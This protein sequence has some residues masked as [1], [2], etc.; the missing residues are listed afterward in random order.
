[1][2]GSDPDATLHWL[3]RMTE[4]GENPEFIARRIVICAAEDVGLA[5]PMALVVATSALQT[6]HFVGWPEAR[7][8]LAEAAL[9]IACAPKSNA[10]YMAIDAAIADA[11]RI[12]FNEVPIHL[13][14]SHYKGAKKFGHGINYKYPHDFPGH[15]TPQE[16]RPKELAE[17]RYYF[18]SKNGKEQKIG[19]LLDRLRELS[20]K[21]DQ[22]D[23]FSKI[24][25]K[26]IE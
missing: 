13:R 21:K 22:V 1:M 15:Y 10:A 17:K 4:A 16:Y 18:P 11:R 2:R 9:Y 3:A 19:E 24:D 25:K 6:V 26:I 12:P 8:A 14:D 23:N 7:I 5:D 20:G